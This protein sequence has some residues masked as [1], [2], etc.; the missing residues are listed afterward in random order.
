MNSY[1]DVA[2]YLTV[3]ILMV[4]QEENPDSSEYVGSMLL[5]H[6]DP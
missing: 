5:R 1:R 6:T 2:E 4:S 3:S